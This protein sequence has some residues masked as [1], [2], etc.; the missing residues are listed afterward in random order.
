MS[1]EPAANAAVHHGDVGEEHEVAREQ[2]FGLLVEHGEIAVAVRGRP[3]PQHKGSRAEI[4][5]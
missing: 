2:G 3:C 5:R 1:G 4:E